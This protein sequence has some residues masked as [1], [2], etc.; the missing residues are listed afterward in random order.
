MAIE[1]IANPKAAY[2][3]SVPK[4]DTPAPAE[5][6]K[7]MPE[8]LVVEA[9][10]AELPVKAK[11][12]EAPAKTKGEKRPEAVKK[13]ASAKDGRTEK[14]EEAEQSLAGTEAMR[15]AVDEI[16]RHIKHSEVVFG[17]HDKTNRVTIKIVDKESRKVVREFPPEQ[18]LDMIAKVWEIAGIMV[19][20]KG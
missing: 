11:A 6:A 9:K 18:T 3:G 10:A 8:P 14:P 15:K 7:K 4:V 2:Q 1:S 17:I 20:E 13:R 12:P 19:D 16:N 5:G